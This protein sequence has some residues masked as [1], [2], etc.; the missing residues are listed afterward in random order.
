[1]TKNNKEPS[2]VADVVR[3]EYEA[4]RPG[5]GPTGLSALCI[6]GGGIRSAT[7]GLGVIQGLAERGLLEQ[8]DYLSTVSGGGYIGSWLTAWSKREGGVETVAERLGSQARASERGSS[9]PVGHLREYSR[10]LAPGAGGLSS[11]LWT[12]MA[13]V[14]RNIVL[15]W[16]VLIPLLLALLLVPR[17]YLSLL[18]LPERLFGEVLFRPG[19]PPDYAAPAL[20][21]ISHSVFVYPLLPL[22]SGALFTVGLF[23]TLR[24][25]PGVGGRPHTRVD[26]HFAILGPLLAAVLTYLA[27]DSLGYLGDRYV[28]YSHVCALVLWTTI[29]CAC[30]WLLFLALDPRPVRQRLSL[31]TGPLPLAI[32]V[33]AA[34]TGVTTWAISNLLLWNVDA[35]LAPSWAFYV[36]VGPPAMLL[37][38]SLGTIL[39]AGL[40]SRFLKDEDREWLSRSSAG[41]LLACVAWGALA[42]VV[43]IL[44]ALALSWRSW[45]AGFVAAAAAASALFSRISLPG[46][47][48]ANPESEGKLSSATLT[49]VVKMAP[50]VFI[51]L[52]AIVLSVFTNALLGGL[53]TLTAHYTSA[54]AWLSKFL[55]AS[56]KLSEPD[57]EPL[58]WPDHYGILTRSNLSAL[59]ALSVGFLGLSW[60]MA[61]YVNI[62]TFSLHGMYRDRLVRAY[63]GASNPARRPNS[64]T[65]F[66][67]NDDTKIADLTAVRPLHIVNVTLNIVSLGRLSWQ[68]RKAASFTITPFH[69]GSAELG[70]RDS[71]SYAG[72]ISLGTAVAISGA[73]ASPSMGYYSSSLVG[74]IMTLFNARLGSWLGN[75]GPAGESTW[76]HAGPRSAVRSLMAEALGLTSDRSEYVYLSDGGHFENLGLYEI[77]RRRCR[78]IF[79]VDSGCDPQF[80]LGDLGNALRKIRIDFGISIDFEPAQIEAL[81]A[82]KSRFAT[83]MVRYSAVDPSLLDGVLVYM[84]PTLL[85]TEPPDVSSYAAVHP[86][87]PHQSTAD[88][89]FDESQT[90]S[91]RQL[92]LGTVREV[93]G[94]WQGAA[95]G[96]L[97]GHLQG[98]A[99]SLQGAV[100]AERER[101]RRLSALEGVR[102]PG[103]CATEA[104]D[105]GSS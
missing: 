26:Y 40:S 95:I 27:F 62:N 74:F 20:N 21:A 11:D 10:Y 65:D 31:V 61:R 33:M 34:G 39:F 55:V 45:G 90:E 24:F 50:L 12:L 41:V 30:A 14:L 104:A 38:F 63:L 88:Q 28:D 89:S 70:Y 49:A 100:Q 35:A 37:G 29:P 17:F 68:D 43:L 15:N 58:S 64:F 53:E 57:G 99:M 3:L 51:A 97:L 69:C 32:A 6:S 48:N 13:G 86:T 103:Q 66:D 101:P 22:V 23:N 5:Q 91:Y 98:G 16:L 93:C 42:C 19:K 81:V 8:L 18:A 85:G 94:A 9:D 80:T 52:L 75:P 46:P 36:T 73:A 60:L 82:K 79:V 76:R 59:L 1:M 56:A 7:F 2:A 87:F 67:A 83:A 4:L 84:K 77:V 78:S 72:G 105:G 71:A 96:E 25:L 92:G 102:E 47:S 54:P 44:P